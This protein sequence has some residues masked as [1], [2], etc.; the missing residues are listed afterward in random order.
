MEQMMENKLIKYYELVHN[1][2]TAQ[3]INPNNISAETYINNL[4]LMADS[5]EKLLEGKQDG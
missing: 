3:L 2:A 5:M 4:R 1:M